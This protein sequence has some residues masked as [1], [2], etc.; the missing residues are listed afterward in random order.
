MARVSVPDVASIAKAGSAGLTGAVTL[1]GGT[2]VT[3]TQ[4]GQDISIAAA[5]G[6][7]GGST[8]STDNRIL[9]ADGTGGATLQNSG[10]TINDAGG[11][12]FSTSSSTAPIKITNT[13]AN[14]ETP[15]FDVNGV[16][17]VTTGLPGV[18]I[19]PNTNALLD[20]GYIKL[21]LNGEYAHDFGEGE[22][23]LYLTIMCEDCFEGSTL[24]L[25]P[26][27]LKRIDELKVGDQVISQNQDISEQRVNT[28]KEISAHPEAKG[29]ILLNEKLKVSK[30]HRVWVNDSWKHVR[31]IQI[32]DYLR[33]SNNDKVWVFQLTPV[34]EPCTTYNLIMDNQKMANYFADDLLV[35]NKCPFLYYYDEG[36]DYP[37]IC[38]GTFIVGKD[39]PEKRGVDRIKLKNIASK[40]FIREIE[41]ETSVIHKVRLIASNGTEEIILDTI[42][43]QLFPCVITQ[44]QTFVVNFQPIPP[45]TIDLWFEADGYYIEK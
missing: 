17:G 40:F 15:L 12:E 43:P 28:I 16:D 14:L 45:N 42:G 33:N 9:R 3:L 21:S 25:T 22:R 34:V 31:D 29:Y 5:S 23:Y 44:G 35:H 20:V 11:A 8:G 19:G 4:S 32:G 2:N 41:P 30:T 1:T 37:W 24:I 10:G 26:Q 18:A 36:A 6:G 39:A 13:D 7:I 38:Q 27:G